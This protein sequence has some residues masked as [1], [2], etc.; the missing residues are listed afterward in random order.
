MTESSSP[1][2]SSLATILASFEPD[3]ASPHP[4]TAQ[5]AAHMARALQ[6]RATELQSPQE[7]RQQAEL[8]RLTRSPHDKATLIQMTDQAFRSRDPHRAAEQLA[9]ILDVQGIP[10]FFSPLDRALL[11]GFQS[12]GGYLPGVAVPLVKDKMREE[13][14]NVILPAEEE[15]LTEHLDARRRVGVRMNVN[16]LGE[17]LLGEREAERRLARYL[18]ALQHDEIECISVKISTIYSQ[19]SS[20]AF[21]HT[22]GVLADRLE[23]LYRAAARARFRHA[24]GSRTAKFV[25]LDMEEYR[26]MAVTAEAFMRT[27]DRPGLESVQAGIALQAY[28]PDSHAVQVRVCQWARKRL[29]A[30][31]A[32][33]TIRLV[34]G[35]N[36]EMERLEASLRGWPQAPFRTKLET[37]ANYKRML[38]TAMTPEN[39][40]AVRLGVASHN[41]FDLA[42]ALVL[43]HERSALDRVQFEMLEGMAN[44]ERR[45]L[46]EIAP[47]ILLYAP[48]TR[49]EDFLY[50]IGYLVRRLDENTGEDNFLRHAFK[51][52]VDSEEWQRLE[53]GFYDAFAAIERL[54]DTPRRTQDRQR[55]L[56]SEVEASD[57]DSP[58]SNEADTDF[59][60]PANV[61]W[62][63]SIAH[64]WKR[65]HGEDARDVPIV[66]GGTEILADRTVHES[67]DPSRPGVAVARWHEATDADVE[68]AVATARADP[69]AWRDKSYEERSAV[70][71]L[72]AAELR[73]ARGDLMGA[74]MAE[75]GKTFPESDPEVSEAIDFVE[76]YRR[77]AVELAAV[78]GIE[79]AGKGVVAVVAPWNFPISI[80][81]GGVAAALAAGNTVILKPAPDTVLTAYELCCCFWRGG[82]PTDVLQF[83][84]GLGKTVGARLVSHHGVDG[85]VFTGGTDTARAMKAAKPDMD[86]FAETGG[87]NAIIVTD[88]CDRDQAIKHVVQSAFG[89]SGQKCSAASLLILEAGVYDDPDFEE[90]LSD[91]V[92]SLGVGSAWEPTTRVVP[93]IHAPSSKLERGLKELEPGETWAVMPRK[94]DDNPSLWSPGVKWG[95]AP[96]SFTHTTE[97]FGPVLGVVRAR[98]VSEAI[99]F[100]NQTGYGLT[101]GLETLD[102][103]EIEL[104]IQR[105]RA[106]NLYV[107]RGITGA[108]VLRQPFGGMGKSALGAGIKAGG[109]NYVAQLMRFR[110][111][112]APDSGNEV[113]DPDLAELSDVLEEYLAHGN[114]LIDSCIPRDDVTAIV[115]AIA[116]YDLAVRDEFGRDHDHFRL[117]G[118]DNL[119]RY[120]PLGDVRI[121]VHAADTAFELF[122]RV[123][124]AKAAGN[125][126]TVSVPEGLSSPGLELLERLTEPWGAQ[127]ELV[128][129]SDDELALAIREHRTERVRYAARARVPAGIFHAVGDTGIYVAHAAVV[130]AG[131]IELLWYL[132]EQSISVDYHRYGNLVAR[133]DEVRAEVL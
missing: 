71:A 108:V 110:N 19:I 61:E 98:N 40:E 88:L 76:M 81:C 59:S 9:H 25:Y 123:C 52:E 26:D 124:A 104:W 114:A 37:D 82:V 16:F 31:G 130:E 106:G 119:R 17:A 36:M 35:A 34:K 46:Q 121:R 6:Q 78:S 65:V 94:D 77:S 115:R 101:S 74:A 32:A 99:S 63:R 129:E 70:L 27:L 50:A 7:R 80:P 89:H 93:L 122:A 21:E 84:P 96:G 105:V 18:E 112:G 86:L 44:H 127:V 5:K 38:Q 47:N 103:R 1:R 41:L 39:L 22:V 58:F 64:R 133:A 23:L 53:A 60:L 13:T 97:L 83:V 51:L 128:D 125:H 54:T 126:V 43:T 72:V 57:A 12:F 11:R 102:D 131:R 66:T 42:Y 67:L 79:A 3:P 55:E 118:Q 2:E 73:S 20:L 14:A 75:A 100:V 91:A 29:A 33:V 109:P 8:E 95:V 132:R 111:A 15:L 28:L 4:L 87:K 113:A 85:V 10:R 48:A 120:L 90:R 62:A 24:D 107:N 30:G 116:S 68:Q 117:V 56:G 69:S 92:E 45:A 49:R